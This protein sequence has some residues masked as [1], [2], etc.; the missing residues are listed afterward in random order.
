MKKMKK[1]S[2]LFSNLFDLY[3]T[4]DN[5]ITAINEFVDSQEY[6]VV[7]KRIKINKKKMLRKA[8]LRC[9]KDEKHKYEKF[10]KR[11]TFSRQCECLFEIIIILKNRD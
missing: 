2:L 9:D 1:M 11:E 6:V 8:I 3:F 7:R 4:L 5:L 10:E